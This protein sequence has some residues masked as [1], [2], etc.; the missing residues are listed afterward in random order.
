MWHLHRRD[1]RIAPEA[2][3]KL[4]VI[5]GDLL[6]PHCGVSGPNRRVLTSA[7]H[8]SSAKERGEKWEIWHAQQQQQQLLH[9]QDEALRQRGLQKAAMQSF[10]FQ[11]LTC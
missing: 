10:H 4:S 5:P 1:G 11:G 6:L 9:A 8:I 3:V 7:D 2:A